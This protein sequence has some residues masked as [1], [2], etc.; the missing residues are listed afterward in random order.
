MIERY[1]IYESIM[2][3]CGIK[4]VRQQKFFFSYICLLVLLISFQFYGLARGEIF[5]LHFGPWDFAFFVL[6]VPWLLYL[7]SKGKVT[8]T[9]PFFNLLFLIILFTLWLSIVLLVSS[10][11]LFRALTMFLLHIRN[12]VIFLMVGT[13]L[14]RTERLTIFNRWIF[15]IS[16]VIAAVAI[17]LYGVKWVD[18]SA[19]LA[20][21][22]LWKPS[23]IYILDQGGVLR[24][25]GFAKDPNFYSL[26]I[27]PA[28]FASL[29]LGKFSL[30]VIVGLLIIS[31]SL[32]LAMSRGFML[33]LFVSTIILV[34]C[35]VVRKAIYGSRFRAY[36]RRLL[37]V[38]VTLVLSGILLQLGGYN[39][40][41]FLLK[42]IELA[43]E[44]PRFEMWSLLSKAM[45]KCWNPLFGSG[46][47]ST[48]VALGGLYSHN[49]YIDILFETGLLGFVLWVSILVYV[50]IISL[51]R[52]WFDEA[53]M[54][55]VQVWF[56][57]LTMFA[58]F[59]LVYNPFPWVVMGVLCSGSSGKD[60]WG[61]TGESN[62]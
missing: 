20:T 41:G 62:Y 44:T 39:V 13:L 14:S 11:E 27:S 46:L 29:A 17:F 19:I 16:L 9:K 21:P 24:L 59:S 55:W 49:S 1:N 15:W 50:S 42:R 5:A 3:D 2:G 45:Q 38:F 31:V 40:S 32:V 22:N 47:R 37:G 52:A 7:L 4:K 34:V 28:L 33:A 30:A 51:R 48:Q 61:I 36:T 18:Y 57:V 53:L 35:Q 54:P 60:V 43:K 23:I 10:Y 8:V 56:V 6:L 26:W 12:V 58:G 25:T